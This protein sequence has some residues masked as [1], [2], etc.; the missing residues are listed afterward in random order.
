[1]TEEIKVEHYLTLLALKCKDSCFIR[2]YLGVAS[3]LAPPAL[4]PPQAVYLPTTVCPT[5]VLKNL[6]LR[7]FAY[8]LISSSILVFTS[9]TDRQA[10]IWALF[11]DISRCVLYYT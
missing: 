5:A 10:Y 9:S 4:S 6:Y 1:M 2:Y 7:L 11:N 8:L 3:W